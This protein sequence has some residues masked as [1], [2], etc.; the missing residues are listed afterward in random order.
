MGG[1]KIIF[2]GSLKKGY[3]DAQYVI[4]I[5]SCD[6]LHNFSVDFYS[7]GNGVK[8][9]KKAGNNIYLKGWV[10]KNSLDKAYDKADAFISIAEKNGKQM[11]SKIFEYMSFGKPI[12]HIYYVDDDI[13]LKYLEKYSKALCIKA[14]ANDIS[15]VR[16]LIFLF[17]LGMKNRKIDN[18]ICDDLNKCTPTKI[19][20]EIEKY[21]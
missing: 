19:V 16:K 20:E 12:I 8:I 10:D 18:Y 14:D 6:L 9:V 21:F 15:Y 11:S 17:L 4:D 13:N 5:F 2:A 7:A 1:G 3:V